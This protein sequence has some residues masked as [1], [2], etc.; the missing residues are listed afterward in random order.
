MRTYVITGATGHTGKPIAKGLLEQGHTVR[1]ISRNAEKAKE[2]T[3]L[4][5]ILF[6]GEQKDVALLKRAFQGADAVYA[7][8]PFEAGAPDYLAMQI[9]HASAMAQAIQATGVKFAVTLSSVGAHMPE[10]AGVVQGL[11]KMEKLFNAVPGLN[12]RHLRASYFMENTLAQAGAIKFMG[13]MASPVRA[14]LKIPMVATRDIAA[15]GLKRL[16]ALD[17]T[18]SS[19][20]YILGQRDV[21]YNEVAS[22]LGKAIGRPD[23]AYVAV[24]YEDGKNAMVGMGMGVSVVD[25]MM[26]FVKAMNDGLAL[27]EATRTPENTTPTSIEDFA[28]VF[29]AVFEG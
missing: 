5:A 23:L 20:E 24:S 17:F 4:G 27:A 8:I 18:G 21:T 28:P 14:D 19:F 7:M 26:E 15:V 16:L 1:I 11:E 22:V 13:V 9:A 29:K 25:R 6:E 3:D 12:V 2:L 10:G